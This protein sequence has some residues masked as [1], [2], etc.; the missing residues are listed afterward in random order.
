MWFSNTDNLSLKIERKVTR[1]ICSWNTICL[2]YTAIH[3]LHGLHVDIDYRCLRVIH[4]AVSLLTKPIHTKKSCISSK[5]THVCSLKLFFNSRVVFYREAQLVLYIHVGRKEISKHLTRERLF[6]HIIQC[7]AHFHECVH[8][9]TLVWHYK[10]QMYRTKRPIIL[11]IGLYF[12]SV[13]FITQEMCVTPEGVVEI[14][15]Q[16]GR[17]GF[18]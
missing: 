7:I 5:Y 3:S 6:A 8:S 18:L 15:F 1:V 13:S 11:G 12:R 17:T 4:R 10:K 2:Y 14:F 16:L 9:C